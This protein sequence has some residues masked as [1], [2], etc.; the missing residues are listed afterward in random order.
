MIPQAAAADDNDIDSL[1]TKKYYVKSN[2]NDIYFYGS[3]DTESCIVLREN[4]QEVY[5]NNKQI[6][7]LLGIEKIPIKLHIQSLGGSV[8]P[9]FALVDYIKGL[10]ISI[11][12]YIEGFAASAATLLSVIASK[13]YMT[14]NSMMLIHQLSAGAEGSYSKMEEEMSN[15]NLMMNK[16]KNIYL[17]NST[18]NEKELDEILK[19]NIWLTPAQCLEYGLIDK[20]L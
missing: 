10:D 3:I 13:R 15:L 8:L 18:L 1:S 16:I 4:I 11:S 20:I 7:T 6:E 17:E 19:K 5:N 9:M 14:K 2:N 12:S